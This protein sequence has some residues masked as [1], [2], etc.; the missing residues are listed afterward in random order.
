MVEIIFTQGEVTLRRMLST[1]PLHIG[2]APDNGLSLMDEQLSWYHAIIW[3]EGGRVWIRDLSS[4][5]GTFINDERLRDSGTATDDDRIRL[6]LRIQ[7]RVRG[8]AA[9]APLQCYAL[10][11]LSR[12][13]R[14]M[15]KV[16][17][18]SPEQARELGIALPGPLT[19]AAGGGLSMAVGDSRVS[20]RIGK[21]FEGTDGGTLRVVAASQSRHRTMGAHDEPYPYRLTVRLDG[22]R[23]PEAVLLDRQTTD[24]HQLFS[25]H[26]VILLYLLARQLKA[27]LSAGRPPEESGWCDND[28]IMLGIWGKGT[29]STSKLAVLIHRVRKEITQAGFDH[30]FLEKQR[31]VLRARL[32]DVVI[33]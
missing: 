20:L 21:P 28:D 29:R 10:E 5:N 19:L 32:V 33:L 6:G 12:K 22:P 14:H 17:V 2:R 24:K 13:V 8:L 3:L 26:R 4:K 1:E 16:G 31:K 11:D 7:V 23:G 25:E 27:D 15:L 30:R 9:T 18:L